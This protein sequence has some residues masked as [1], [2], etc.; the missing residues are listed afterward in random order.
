MLLA[1]LVLFS[2][3][4]CKTS[5]ASE[6]IS[7]TSSTQGN[8]LE[9]AFLEDDHFE[10]RQE[11]ITI[12]YGTP[13][14]DDVSEYVIA[15]DYEGITCKYDEIE[16]FDY[17]NGESGYALFRNSYGDVLTMTIYYTDTTPPTIGLTEYTF[18]TLHQNA[19]WRDDKLV[20][21]EKIG[22]SNYGEIG[23][24][25]YAFDCS[26]MKDLFN[27]TDNVGVNI[28][29]ITVDDTVYNYENHNFDLGWNR[30]DAEYGSH[31]VIFNV[32]DDAGNTSTFE[33]VLHIVAD[34]SPEEREMLISDYGYTE[35][36][37]N[38][39]VDAFINQN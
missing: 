21:F 36:E 22:T 29:S 32:S 39:A 24:P 15:K 28:I 11:S 17:L 18:C 2:L 12:E 19:I 37:I 16:Y 26:S 25:E 14:S 23:S 27:I 6:E 1:T 33:C 31:K 20:L 30:I 10:L 8:L 4:G 3:I 38:A 7:E 34:V 5:E 9:S 35:E 13:L